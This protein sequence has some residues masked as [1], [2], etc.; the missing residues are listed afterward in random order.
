M[1][2]ELI[3]PSSNIVAGWSVNGYTLINDAITQPT[4]PS[5]SAGTYIYANKNDDGEEDQYGFTA[6]AIAGTM[7]DAT[8]W[9]NGWVYT[10]SSGLPYT[11][12]TIRIRLNGSWSSYK[13]WAGGHSTDGSP[14]FSLNWS[15]YSWT[16]SG[17][18]IGSAPAVGFKNAASVAVGEDWAIY[19]CYLILTTTSSGPSSQLRQRRSILTRFAN[20]N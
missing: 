16:V 3:R 2:T 1:A 13:P 11:D 7:T 14:S 9:V 17:N 12:R 20:L 4:D 19:A 10:Y 8:L 15:S 6:P 5:T 18:A